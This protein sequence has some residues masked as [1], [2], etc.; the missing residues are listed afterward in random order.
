MQIETPSPARLVAVGFIATGFLFQLF[1][2]PPAPRFDELGDEDSFVVLA[3]DQ[4]RMD[5]SLPLPGEISSI[6]KTD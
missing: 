4:Q 1:A 2:H 6:S 5:R 3:R